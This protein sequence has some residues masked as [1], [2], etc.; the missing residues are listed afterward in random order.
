MLLCDDSDISVGVPSVIDRCLLRRDEGISLLRLNSNG[1][2]TRKPTTVECFK[3]L[4][5]RSKTH[6]HLTSIWVN[7]LIQ[8]KPTAKDLNDCMTALDNMEQI[9]DIDAIHIPAI[10]GIGSILSGLTHSIANDFSKS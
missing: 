3:R 10:Y 2:M 5:E 4:N 1:V 9:T 6:P 7:Y 8:R